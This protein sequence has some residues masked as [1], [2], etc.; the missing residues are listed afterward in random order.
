M[1][2]KQNK[3][4]VREEKKGLTKKQRSWIYTGIFIAVLLILFVVN[5]SGN[6]PEE[7]PLPPNYAK[8]TAT[9]HPTA[10]NFALP[11]PDGKRLKLS[12]FRGKVVILDFWA[13]WCPP[14]RRGIP[15]LIS[16]KAKY[17]DKGLEVIGVS[18]DAITRGTQG[19]VIPFMKEYGINYPIV[20]GDIEITRL[21]GGIRSIPTTFVIDRNGKIISNFVGLVPKTT[22]EAVVVNAL[23]Q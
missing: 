21:Y 18:L 22:L 10:P 17:K 6:E 9:V 14:C 16:L 8:P 5:N 20:F 2:K 4:E 12:D 15:D 3:T 7:G 23:N 13:T 11:T 1:S 19:R